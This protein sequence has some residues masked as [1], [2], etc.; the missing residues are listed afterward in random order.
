VGKKGVSGKA[1]I[2]VLLLSIH[3][4]LHAYCDQF[5]VSSKAAISSSIPVPIILLQHACMLKNNSC[6]VN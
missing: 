5:N 2:H 4:I 6:E 1:A 3:M